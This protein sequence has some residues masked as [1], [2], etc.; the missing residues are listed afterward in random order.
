MP[1]KFTSIEKKLIAILQQDIPNSLTPFQDIAVQL[2]VSERWVINKIR[3]WL[4]QGIIRRFGA[5][6]YHR[7]IGFK[8]NAMVIWKVPK[9]RVNQVGK[10]M[11]SFPEVSHCY[12]R[13]TYP[14]WQYNLYTMVHGQTKK[15]CERVVRRISQQTGITDYQLLYSMREFKKQSMK[16]F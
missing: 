9:S 5:I 12:E 3:T 15:D 8:A 4:K 16:Y 10:I 7:K 2:G 11:A 1:K 6:V 14:H 13:V